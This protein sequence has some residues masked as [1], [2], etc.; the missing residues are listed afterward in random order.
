MG[1]VRVLGSAGV[2]AITLCCLLTHRF[3]LL[4]EFRITILQTIWQQTFRALNLAVVSIASEKVRCR[5][6]RPRQRPQ[7]QPMTVPVS[8][9]SHGVE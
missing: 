5:Y 3:V 6:C 1:P 9:D 8:V 2:A 4:A 7:L